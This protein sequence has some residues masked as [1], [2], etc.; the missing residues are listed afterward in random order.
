MGYV[1]NNAVQSTRKLACDHHSELDQKM[2]VFRGQI[3]HYC[4][5]PY[6]LMRL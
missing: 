6:V 1:C 5:S 4:A 2:E 3:I